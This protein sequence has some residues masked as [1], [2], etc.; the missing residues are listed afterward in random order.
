MAQDMNREESALR[1]SDH[2]KTVNDLAG[3]PKA[4]EKT[5]EK[6]VIDGQQAARRRSL[7]DGHR[8]FTLPADV[9]KPAVAAVRHG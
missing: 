2:G 8:V 1:I 3:G 7:E 4:C 5:G 6:P 9:H